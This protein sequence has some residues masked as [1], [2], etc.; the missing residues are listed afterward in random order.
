MDPEQLHGFYNV[1]RHRGAKLIRKNGNYRVLSC[2]YH[3]WGYAGD[4]R[5]LAT[6]L[7]HMQPLLRLCAALT[8]YPLPHGANQFKG[9]GIQG[10]DEPEMPKDVKEA[11]STEHVVNFHKKVSV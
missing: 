11:L 8:R 9:D 10:H 2:P 5:L 1:C 4:G 6:P 3:R 7:V